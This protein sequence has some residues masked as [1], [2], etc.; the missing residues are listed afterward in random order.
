M[1][2]LLELKHID[3]VKPKD[4]DK[5]IIKSR[6]S[7]FTA[8]STEYSEWDQYAF[9]VQR[10]MWS[11]SYAHPNGKNTFSFLIRSN[12]LRRALREIIGE[13]PGVNWTSSLVE[14]CALL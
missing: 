1:G 10:T 11:V 13:G 3:K 12:P 4:S 5:W 6:E 8:E 14:V 7:T 9:L 2:T